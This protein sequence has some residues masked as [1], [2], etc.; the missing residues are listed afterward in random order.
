MLS[1]R[2]LLL[3][4]TPTFQ[5]NYPTIASYVANDIISSGL[6][7]KQRACR[8]GF[9]CNED[10]SSE[11]YCGG[12]N[13]WCSPRS[14]QPTPVTKGYYSVGGTEL[15]R[16]S[17]K[18]C[19]M[20]FYC[21]EGVRHP[22]PPGQIGNATG[23]FSS[24]CSGPCP[25]GYY[26]P[27]FTT[28]HGV[29]CGNSTVYCPAGSI[30]P[31]IV[32][33][34][35][36]SITG[37]ADRRTQQQIAPEGSYAVNGSVFKCPPGRYGA[38]T[39]QSNSSC[40]GLC[41]AGYY[42]TAGSTIPRQ[43][44]CG[45]EHRYCPAGSGEPTVVSDGY[46]TSASTDIC[47]PGFWRNSSLF[48]DQS[49]R[50]I[51]LH[52]A[53]PTKADTPLCI[54][55]EEGTFKYQMGDS[56]SLCLQCP[57]ISISSG[58][59]ISCNCPRLNNDHASTSL[60]FN[61][62]SRRCE[63]SIYSP[64]KLEALHSGRILPE[65]QL[66]KTAQFLCEPGFFC[67]NGTRFPCPKGFFGQKSGE[68][69]PLCEGTCPPGF[70]CT[71]GTI[72]P[73]ICGRIDLFCPEGSFYPRKASTGYETYN[74]MN[75]NFSNTSHVSLSLIRDAE[76]KCPQGYFC[77]NGIKKRC[78][79][80]RFGGEKGQSDPNCSG[81]CLPG[82]YCP[83][84]STTNMQRKCGNVTVYCPPASDRPV[85]A[86]NGYYTVQ[87]ASGNGLQETAHLQ[88][89]CEKGYFCLEGLRN[90]C[91]PGTYGQIEGASL[92]ATACKPCA[93]GHYCPSPWG[94][95]RPC[96]SEQV[97]CPEQSWKPLVVDVAF[98]SI[99]GE[100]AFRTSQE[101][102]PKGHYCINGAK[103]RCAAGRYGN[104]TGPITT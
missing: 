82:Y 47:G 22:C 49:L 27:N 17:Q 39:G 77:I 26:C 101:V 52:S 95:P 6:K 40:S 35:F 54:L 53:I 100:S 14:T 75:S 37:P 20:G 81:P 2:T 18:E 72:Q 7:T 74:D 98:Y 5:I 102:C 83:P 58:D 50:P 41:D 1:V 64:S 43:F 85:F 31:K 10:D 56:H 33:V 76:R 3:L 29:L 55:C 28:V 13:W 69:N 24:K 79:G 42:C 4:F 45:G 93:E 73:D 21:V 9:Y 46:Y 104:S 96:G 87:R 88:L 59:R 38:T 51:V 71:G 8:A 66:T 48:I 12:N 91:P 15:S 86:E 30:F 19:E 92:L 68:T 103:Y 61:A 60:Y 23:L 44:Y 62:T 36:Y 65:T 94:S 32:S 90:Q 16:I 89:K 67:R 25:E 57:I 99:G 11:R 63:S 80:G 97:Y 70:Y 34:G 78:K 84:G